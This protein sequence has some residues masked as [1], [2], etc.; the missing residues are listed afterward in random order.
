MGETGTTEKT[1]SQVTTGRRK[2]RQPPRY[3][4]E[5]PLWIRIVESLLTMLGIRQ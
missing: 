4:H 3:Y 1:P 2:P 5:L